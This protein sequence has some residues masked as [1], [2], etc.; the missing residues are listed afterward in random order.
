MNPEQQEGPAWDT[1][2]E[3]LDRLLDSAEQ[4]MGW[5]P[6]VLARR[7]DELCGV[8]TALRREVEELLSRSNDRHDVLDNGLAAAMPEILE[9]LVHCDEARAADVALS[10]RGGVEAQESAGFVGRRIDRYRLLDILGRGGMGVVYL[11]ERAD[12]QFD[13]RVALKVMPR[14]LE[15]PERER[16]FL[17]ERQILARLEHEHIARLLDGG[18]TDE[19]YPYLVMELVEGQPIDRYSEIEGLGTRRR[20]ELFLD[21]CSAVHYAHRN[22]VIHRDLKP[23]NIQ[24]APDG[25]VKLLDFGVGK[26]LDEPAGNQRTRFQPMTP[27]YASPEQR[28]NRPVSTA[29]DIYSLG[30]VLHRLLTGT[31]PPRTGRSQSDTSAALDGDLG[32]IVSRAQSEDEN[33]RFGSASEMADDIRRYLQGLPIESRPRSARYRIGKFVGRHRVASA[34]A[35]AA[36]LLAIV[37]VLTI[38]RQNRI[39]A[40]ERDHAR[41]EARRAQA[42]AELLGNLFGAADPYGEEAGELTARDLLERGESQVRT[43]LAEQPAVQAEMLS[44]I[45]WAYSR[46]GEEARGQELLEAAVDLL[47][48]P[49]S[50]DQLA[51]ARALRR[52]AGIYRDQGRL[53]SA[54]LLLGEAE[55]ILERQ[56]ELESRDAAYLFSELGRWHRSR[57]EDEIAAGLF[58]KSLRLFESLGDDSN[59][60]VEKLDLAVLL[61]RSDRRQ[62]ALQLK[63]QALATLVAIHGENHPLVAGTRNDIA[64]TLHRLGDYQGAETL[65]REALRGAQQTLG[66]EHPSLATNFTNLGKVLM[67]Q[68]RF[69]E[70]EPYLLRAVELRGEDADS[71]ALSR[72]AA[73]MN[74]A[75]LDVALGRYDHAIARY[76]DGLERFEESTGPDSRASSRVRSL[77]GIA[78]HRQGDPVAAEPLL[79][80]AL[81]AQ[82]SEAVPS[83]LAETLV[84]LGAVLS[85]L[86][87][88]EDAEALLREGL[89]LWLDLLPPDHWRVAAARVE[90]AGALLRMSS[91]TERE[92]AEARR[93]LSS[94]KLVELE[95]SGRRWIEARNDLFNNL[96]DRGR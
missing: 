44:T 82:R 43:E 91:P 48:D 70:A 53:D 96:A 68:G 42:V 65:Y 4:R 87:R 30:A 86:G 22:L 89:V 32:V 33:E 81:V 85:D 71:N 6:G 77:L 60:A 92:I 1:V 80:R 24:V 61:D 74:V 31:P 90:L 39:A 84:A 29:T 50:A 41:L 73:E 88:A 94:A 38:A 34:F 66:R 13:K 10:G 52:L 14:G 78:V 93:L 37:A 23:G 76:R 18:V 3:I 72:I 69:L 45:G 67:D 56:G 59:A 12:R 64:I 9:D 75:T 51:L 20:L 16:R 40:R 11:A 7:L 47:R 46:L 17:T 54:G 21:V 27:D 2:E 25:T 57:D 5:A 62:E 63:R 28:A 95:G 83:H 8:D 36:T 19:G 58:R 55:E 15:S 26:I 79:A 49:R 35:A